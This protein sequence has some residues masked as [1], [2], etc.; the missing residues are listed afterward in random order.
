MD[1]PVKKILVYIDGTEES[2]TAA[3][4]ALCLTQFTGAKL[5]A[6]YVINIKALDDL[7]KARIF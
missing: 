6:F 1:S 3:Q 7:L 4:F 2:I 5:T